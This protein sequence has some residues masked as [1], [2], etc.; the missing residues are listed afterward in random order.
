LTETRSSDWSPRTTALLAAIV[1]VVAF[2]PFAKGLLAG[3]SLFF[4]DL[5]RQFFPFRR[6]V[7]EGLLSGELRFWNPLV[8]EGE[9]LSVPPISYPLDLLHVLVPNEWGFSLLLALHVPLAALAFLVLSRGLGLVPVAAGCGAFVYALG[10]FCLSSV[11]LYIHLQAMAWAPLVVAGML[12]AARGGPRDW[13]TGGVLT[14]LALSTTGAEIVAQAALFAI[15]LCLSR[16]LRGLWRLLVVLGLA[17]GLA[18]PTLLV[19][20]DLVAH[21]ARA[22]GFEMWE[23][24]GFSVHPVTL[25]QVLIAGLL[26]D[27]SNLADRFWGV[28]FFKAFPYFLSLY[29]GAAAFSAAAVGA[30]YGRRFGGRLVLLALVAVVV[31]LGSHARLDLV[32]E[33]FPALKAFRYPA[34]VFFTAHLCMAVLVA[35]G[36]DALARDVGGRAWR[37]LAAW[38]L[39][40][41]ALLALSPMLP[42]LLPGAT[43]W[44]LGQFFPE[45]SDWSQRYEIGGFILRDAFTGGLVALAVGAA[46]LLVVKGRL[47]P[48]ASLIAVTALV[49]ADLVRAGAG[50]NPMVS[51]SFFGLSPEMTRL[52]AEI[53][54]SGGRAFTCDPELGTAYWQ[55]RQRVRTSHET[56]TIAVLMETL[57]PHHNMRP[58]VATAYGRDL[59]MLVPPERVLSSQLA[60]CAAF[61]EI[62]DSLHG[63]GVSHVLSLEPIAHPGLRLRSVE[64]PARIAPL[65]VY[66]YE[67][68]P[69][70]ELRF[71]AAQVIPAEDLERARALAREPGL[72]ANR[73]VVVEGFEGS[74][75]DAS[76]RVVWSR[77]SAGRIELEVEADR[78]T[79][80]VLREAHSRGWSARVN[81]DAVPVLRADGRHRA[82][83]VPA[84]TSRVILRY[85][86]P[87]LR[88]GLAWLAL[89]LLATAGLVWK[90]RSAPVS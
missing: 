33:V 3:R 41:G 49:G 30:R 35:L 20:R 54:Q 65:A 18:A 4:R 29:L 68:V 78:P 81:G 38:G 48:A 46:A 23:V 13:A 51:A 76:G 43:G 86:A 83:P 60:G 61:E 87:G 73:G 70:L 26:G 67:L 52:A 37:L 74:V 47:K 36:L 80:V 8:H 40:L 12:R 28:R 34:K 16:R 19:V 50:L 45:E 6:F 7:V 64:E 1:G 88:P 32:V 2:L 5:S 17:A 39:G 71:V 58:G 62:F 89:S 75:N 59:T 44:A 53:K 72:R 24:L 15:V 55:A 90:G 85:R 84:G 27:P 77:A 57:T 63:A 82:V 10:G 25:L 56:W 14:A 11:N 31:T 21:S 79:V 9:P 42:R 66:V 69:R 22:A